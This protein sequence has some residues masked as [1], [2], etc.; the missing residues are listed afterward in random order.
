LYEVEMI[1]N[2]QNRVANFVEFSRNISLSSGSVQN[3]M[4]VFRTWFLQ[5]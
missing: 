2:C 4:C 1:P 3:R 5:V